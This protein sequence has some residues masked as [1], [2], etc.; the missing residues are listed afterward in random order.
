MSEPSPSTPPPP[1]QPPIDPRRL[2]GVLVQRV[3]RAP[4]VLGGTVVLL[5]LWT[6]A[7]LLAG[8]KPGERAAQPPA[9][10]PNAESSPGTRELVQRFLEES[11]RQAE[12][13]AAAARADRFAAQEPG[14]FYGAPPPPYGPPP[15]AES[16]PPSW[17]VRE[18][19]RRLDRRIER[20]PRDPAAERLQRALEASPLVSAGRQGAET[21]A[22]QPAS[23]LEGLLAATE[24]LAQITQ[25]PA[26]T[27]PPE[28]FPEGFPNALP[29]RLQPAT[30]S[31]AL[32]TSP[33]RPASPFTLA[34]GTLLPAVLTSAANS[35]APGTVSAVVN[36]DVFD[37][38]T[39][40]FLLVPAGSRLLGTS[41]TAVHGQ[42][43]LEITWSRLTLPDGTTYELGAMPAADSSG[44]TG[45]RDRTN[46]H[47]GRTFGSA[48][49]LSVF[50]AAA[51]LSQ[52]N[53][54]SGALRAPT[55]QEIAAGALGQQVNTTAD[56]L[57]ERELR[58]PPT[59][60]LRPGTTC[61]VV[62]TT[63]LVFPGP[64]RP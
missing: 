39:G 6:G 10:P 59:L 57:I 52:P 14:D 43:R 37:S 15:A 9:P 3:G 61:Q 30:P 55:A 33:N 42:N 28:G 40:A 50:T 7:F 13:D 11:R 58:I 35:D 20:E 60:V 24:R 44:A 2:A 19:P 12:Q 18:E 31:A 54:F 8:K 23:P 4:L 29:A 22:E 47:L 63:D 38:R 51:Q 48:L 21:P 26:P 46:R 17:E 25:Q 56:A 36:R 62:V 64:F 34:A 16:A 5:A 53:S 1:A 32:R 49:L 41:G 27:G 45:V